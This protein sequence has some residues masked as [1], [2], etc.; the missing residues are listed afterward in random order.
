MKEGLRGS[1]PSVDF[2]QQKRKDHPTAPHTKIDARSTSP[3]T[4]NPDHNPA[5][6]KNLELKTQPEKSDKELPDLP[7]W[8]TINVSGYK[9]E[10]LEDIPTDNP[11]I[12]RHVYKM[13]GGLEVTFIEYGLNKPKGRKETDKNTSKESNKEPDTGPLPLRIDHECLCMV[14]G[15]MIAHDCKVQREIATETMANIGRGIMVYVKSEAAM[16]H[17]TLRAWQQQK[18]M[19]QERLAG[20]EPPT[21]RDFYKKAGVEKFDIRKHHEVASLIS[22]RLEAVGYDEKKTPLIL[23][24]SSP[25]KIDSLQNGHK[26]PIADTARVIDANRTDTSKD[27]HT[28][29]NV[30]KSGVYIKDQRGKLV[31][32]SSIFHR[33]M[34]DIFEPR[35]RTEEKQRQQ[36][37]AQIV[38]LSDRRRPTEQTV[39]TMAGAPAAA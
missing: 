7:Q 9:F 26:I 1:P 28:D 6:P 29:G 15:P 13:D 30:K 36:Q 33:Y 20:N 24:G 39:Y 34:K 10:A 23:L 2:A 21:I 22:R 38:N 31:L 17:G 3:K 16:G 11:N 19:M 5:L 14:D 27:Y 32:L 25:E 37:G 4:K 8:E 12:V 18:W 35:Q